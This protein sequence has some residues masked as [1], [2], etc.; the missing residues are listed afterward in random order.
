MEIGHGLEWVF[1]RLIGFVGVDPCEIGIAVGIRVDDGV[2]D[3]GVEF[4]TA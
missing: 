3:G 1:L 2:K 4:H